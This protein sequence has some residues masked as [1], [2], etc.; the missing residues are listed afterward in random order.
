MTANT[1]HTAAPKPPVGEQSEYEEH[2]ANYPQHGPAVRGVLERIGDKWSLLVIISLERGSLRYGA[3]KRQVV[4][5]SQRMLTL[6]LRHLERDGLVVRTAYAEIPP[7]VEY[8]L[9]ALGHTLIAPAR[10]IAHW[11]IN[12]YATI[13]QSRARFDHPAD[14][15]DPQ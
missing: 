1:S 10:S 8:E 3:L 12:N 13:E 15:G 14:S 2:C 7:R 11:A 6:T 4:G 9:T 5:V